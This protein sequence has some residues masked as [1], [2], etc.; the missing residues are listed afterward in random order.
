M[1][2]AAPELRA[3]GDLR[4]VQQAAI[5]PEGL[6]VPHERVVQ[7]RSREVVR[8]LLH[9]VHR[10]VGSER[11]CAI[12]RLSRVASPPWLPPR[13]APHYGVGCTPLG[14][15]PH[16]AKG[17]GW[18]PQRGV[19]VRIQLEGAV[20]S[21]RRIVA[22]EICARG[23]AVV[24]GRVVGQKLAPEGGADA[25]PCKES[26]DLAVVAGRSEAEDVLQRRQH[27]GSD[28]LVRR[29]CPRWVPVVSAG[30]SQVA[31]VA[32]QLKVR[33]RPHASG[34]EVANES[35]ERGYRKGCCERRPGEL[36]RARAVPGSGGEGAAVRVVVVARAVRQQQ[37][38]P[39]RGLALAVA[40][41][42]LVEV[43]REEALKRVA[44]NDDADDGRAVKERR[45][46]PPAKRLE[47]RQLPLGAI[48]GELEPR[49]I[50]VA[51]AALPIEG[52]EE[53]EPLGGAILLDGARHQA[54]SRCNQPLSF[55][56]LHCGSGER[57]PPWV[58][59]A[60]DWE[61]RGI[62]GV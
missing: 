11:L 3:V 51:C 8:H 19:V 47:G 48:V 24:R 60:A 62:A 10:R 54:V 39:R 25:E 2:I 55:E 40:E 36:F 42:A 52:P 13:G 30:G 28:V 21:A 58:V 12:G 45:L 23:S 5:G 7:R 17:R 16:R 1:R 14:L 43:C 46:L 44:H 32:L 61:R 18:K 57:L 26:I 4:R 56:P 22:L 20:P 41:G 50:L 34:S 29:P 53:A 49:G 6:G 15:R 37:R 27:R 59:A 38:R 33:V 31:Q 9:V 35:V